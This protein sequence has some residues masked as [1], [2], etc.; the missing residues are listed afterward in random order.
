MWKLIHGE[1]NILNAVAEKWVR[2]RNRDWQS[3]FEPTKCSRNSFSRSWRSFA[4]SRSASTRPT[5]IG[6]CLAVDSRAQSTICSKDS[7]PNFTATSPTAPNWCIT[8]KWVW[9]WR[10]FCQSRQVLRRRLFA[11]GIKFAFQAR[12]YDKNRAPKLLGQPTVVYFHVTV[13]SIDS[14]NEESMTYVTDIFLAQRYLVAVLSNNSID[15]FAFAFLAALEVGATLDLG[16]LK[17]WA[18]STGFST[19]SGCT[20]SGDPIASSKTPKRSRFTRWRFP[21][22][23]CGFITI[24]RCF[25]CPSKGGCFNAI[26]ANV[27]VFTLVHF[28]LTLVLSCAMK[29]ES[30]PHDIQVCSMMIESCKKNTWQEI[31]DAQTGLSRVFFVSVKWKWIDKVRTTR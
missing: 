14:I 31:L 15:L 19:W 12:S 4:R 25:T 23:T 30:Y 2:N 20:R 29:F 5:S 8:T 22:T 11:F 18:R 16:F 26:W 10:I 27:K 17:I 13:L 6:K 7:S 28:R 24:R 21:I 9:S 3:P 1:V